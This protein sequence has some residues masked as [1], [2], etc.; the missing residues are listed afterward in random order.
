MPR[1]WLSIATMPPRSCN[2]RNPAH[3]CY[4]GI[5]H[6]ACN[7]LLTAFADIRIPR[8]TEGSAH[9]TPAAYTEG[10]YTRSEIAYAHAIDTAAR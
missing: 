6:P 2:T 10:Q 3:Q 8:L 5:L 1:Q 9:A 4:V 7:T